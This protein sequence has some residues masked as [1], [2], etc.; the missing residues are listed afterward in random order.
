MPRGTGAYLAKGAARGTGYECVAVF[1]THVASLKHV[2]PLATTGVLV[3]ANLSPFW[4]VT[5]LWCP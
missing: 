1:A 4:R 2:L 5:F 3:R